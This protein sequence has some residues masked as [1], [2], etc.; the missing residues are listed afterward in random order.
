MA[1]PSLRLGPSAAPSPFPSR[2][3]P[4]AWPPFRLSLVRRTS[5]QIHVKSIIFLACTRP[6]THHSSLPLHEAQKTQ[7]PLHKK[8][9]TGQRLS[10]T[11][12]RCRRALRLGGGCPGALG[13][14][15][16][17]C[18]ASSGCFLCEMPYG[19]FQRNSRILYST[20]RVTT[21]ALSPLN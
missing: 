13:P 12:P 15:W 19:E 8:R 17:T 2:N 1:G 21:L 3:I 10:D 14:A 7:F 6:D 5:F 18:G 16:V 9:L 4:E 11:S 20:F